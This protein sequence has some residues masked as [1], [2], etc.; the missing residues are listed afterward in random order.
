MTGGEW[1]TEI[2]SEFPLKERPFLVVITSGHTELLG[3]AASLA[4]LVLRKPYETRR[5]T[6][7]LENKGLLKR[8]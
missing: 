2:S 7:F 1:L 4:D 5:L 3:E 6:E 8:G